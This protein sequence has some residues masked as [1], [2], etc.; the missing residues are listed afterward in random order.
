LAETA[1]AEVMAVVALAQPA[2][3]EATA[4]IRAAGAASLPDAGCLTRGHA[5]TTA[6]NGEERDSWCAWPADLVRG[7]DGS[8]AFDAR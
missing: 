5:R 2:R 7:R 1:A 4:A 8:G 6:G 3:A